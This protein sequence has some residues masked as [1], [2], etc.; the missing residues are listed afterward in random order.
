MI[1]RVRRFLCWIGLH[2]ASG[3][4]HF[5]SGLVYGHCNG[6]GSDLVSEPLGPWVRV[7]N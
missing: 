5:R 1:K 7:K 2:W 6:C 4:I 3:E